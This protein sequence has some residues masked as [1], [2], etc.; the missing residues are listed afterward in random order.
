MVK[1]VFAL[2]AMLVGPFVFY[3]EIL[4]SAVLAGVGAGVMFY[5]CQPLVASILLAALS[6]LAGLG[7]GLLLVAQVGDSGYGGDS[8]WGHNGIFYVG[9]D[10]NVDI[11]AGDGGG[12]GGDGGGDGGGE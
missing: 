9:N 8:A 11:G 4:F 2:I 7:I 5:W 10:G 1:N 12:D 6:P 3:T